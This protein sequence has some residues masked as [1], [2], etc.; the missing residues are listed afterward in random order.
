VNEASYQLAALPAISFFLAWVLEIP[1]HCVV[2]RKN[3]LFIKVINL[4][5][6]NE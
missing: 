3:I 6:I 4:T 5:G 1:Q 2:S